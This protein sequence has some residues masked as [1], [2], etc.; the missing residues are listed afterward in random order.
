SRSFDGI[1]KTGYLSS[2]KDRNHLMGSI[3][4]DTFFEGSIRSDI[5]EGSRPFCNGIDNNG[6]F[7][8]KDHDHLIGSISY[9]E[10]SR[11]FDGIDKTG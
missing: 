2:P 5:F 8:S 7:P 11:P 9:F 1:E 10:G 6:Q 4:T 3:R